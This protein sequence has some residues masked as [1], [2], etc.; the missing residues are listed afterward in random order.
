MGQRRCIT[1]AAHLDSL[2]A[3]RDWIG[4]ACRAAGIDD[5]TNHDLRLA[6]DEACTNVITHGYAGMNPGSV[7]LDLVLQPHQVRITVTDFGRPFEP[8]AAALPD[9]SLP[10][11]ERQAGG[12]GLFIIHSVM[13][14]V[15]YST[16]EEGNHLVL[17]KHLGNPT[18]VLSER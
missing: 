6:V 7:M 2:P 9:A 5:E 18:G 1:R 16:D 15:G 10:L 17:V 13:D 12:W 11:D 4:E 14:Q 3:L 8:S